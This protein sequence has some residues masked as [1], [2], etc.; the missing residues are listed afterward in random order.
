ME[1]YISISIEWLFR[2]IDVNRSVLNI[3]ISTYRHC[4]SSLLLLLL[5]LIPWHIVMVRSVVRSVVFFFSL[6]PYCVAYMLYYILWTS[7]SDTQKITKITGRAHEKLAVSIERRTGI[8]EC[9]RLKLNNWDV[10]V[11]IREWTGCGTGRD[12]GRGTGRSVT[13]N[14]KCEY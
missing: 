6:P 2:N 9:T 3:R 8:V 11:V 10:S 12:V 14:T 1:M 4:I 5:P 13:N 7:P